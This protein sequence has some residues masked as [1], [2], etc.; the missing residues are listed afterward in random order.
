MDSGS[1]LESEPVPSKTGQF[2]SVFQNYAQCFETYGNFFS[3]F[4]LNSACFLIEY[5]AIA[6]LY[7]HITGI[8]TIYLINCMFKNRIFWRDDCN[9]QEI[10][11]EIFKKFQRW[12][13]RLEYPGYSILG[14]RLGLPAPPTGVVPLDPACFSWTPTSWSR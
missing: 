12:L 3:Y 4:Y 2:F 1:V 7:Q 6:I 9:L 10:F 8:I 5:P 11:F 14:G 13:W